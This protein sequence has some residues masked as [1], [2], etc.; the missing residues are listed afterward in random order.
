[1]SKPRRPGPILVEHEG[2]P[3]LILCA[4]LS[5]NWWNYTGKATTPYARLPQEADF[6]IKP[7]EIFGVA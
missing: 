4:P 3:G 7:D 1:M 2:D 5:T 6:K